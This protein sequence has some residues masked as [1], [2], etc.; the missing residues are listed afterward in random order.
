MKPIFREAL[1]TRGW[2]TGSN[3]L[4][5]KQKALFPQYVISFI[6]DSQPELWQQMEKLHGSELEAELSDTLVKERISKGTLYIIRH[7]FKFYGK[8]FKL[9]YYKPAHSLVPETR[10]LYDKNCLHVT[11]QVPCHPQDGS[12]MDMVLSLNGIPF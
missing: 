2:L 3:Q 1:T 8:V 11:R 12:T 9:A 7:G 5:D 4:W 6:K 10:E